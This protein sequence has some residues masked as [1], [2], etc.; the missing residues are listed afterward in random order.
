MLNYVIRNKCLRARFTFHFIYYYYYYFHFH[1]IIK[2][3]NIDLLVYRKFLYFFSFQQC[4]CHDLLSYNF[5]SLRNSCRLSLQ[6]IC[7]SHILMPFHYGFKSKTNIVFYNMSVTPAW[8][9]CELLCYEFWY[10]YY[11]R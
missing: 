3:A 8:K 4:V 9:V 1:F 2:H 7:W 11:V 5:F 10:Q 6:Q